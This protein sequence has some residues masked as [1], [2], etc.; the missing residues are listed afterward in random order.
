MENIQYWSFQDSAEGEGHQ[1][2]QAEKP[3]PVCAV[4]TYVYI[5]YLDGQQI[6]V[7]GTAIITRS[8]DVSDL[9]FERY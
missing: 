5:R 9:V 6:Q 7:D 3:G 2:L 4:N 1:K 8:S